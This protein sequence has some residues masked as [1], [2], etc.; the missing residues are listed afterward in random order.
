MTALDL[1]AWRTTCTACGAPVV[2][3][4]GADGIE[5]PVS[6]EPNAIH[7]TVLLSVHSEQ[8]HAGALRHN[9]AAGARDQ[10]RPLHTTHL[11]E[12]R[13]QVRPRRRSR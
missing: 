5:L 4:T 9:Q 8:L 7:G 2:W 10:G 12:C 3:A 6:A 1:A 11:T 13:T